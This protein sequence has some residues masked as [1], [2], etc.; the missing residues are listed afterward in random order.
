M[1]EIVIKK[2]TSIA[3]GLFLSLTAGYCLQFAIVPNHFDFPSLYFGCF[4]LSLVLL[5]IN[6]YQNIRFT[7]FNLVPPKPWVIMLFWI[8]LTLVFCLYFANHKYW[9]GDSSRK[10][11]IAHLIIGSYLY[12]FAASSL[13]GS[14]FSGLGFR[15]FLKSPFVWAKYISM[16]RKGEF[17]K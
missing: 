8:F 17:K 4:I 9:D 11:R 10:A 3:C 5:T 2:A 15:L 12:A 13:F 14:F 7:G 16:K 1:P 6:F